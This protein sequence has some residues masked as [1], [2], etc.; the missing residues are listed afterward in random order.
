[1]S[2]LINTSAY[3]PRVRL[4]GILLILMTISLTLACGKRGA[5]IPPNERVRQRV[6]LSAFQRGPEV[7]LSWKMP[8]R[9]AGRS[10]VQNIGRVDV[11]RLADPVNA[12][13]QITEADFSNRSTIVGSVE[14]TNADFANQ[15]LTYRDRLQFSTQPAR[16]RYAVR[17]VN[18]SG[19]RAAFSNLVTVQPGGRVSI[20]PSDLRAVVSQDAI[21]LNWARPSANLD[22]ST[23]ANLIG[24]NIYRSLSDKEPARLLTT[25]P[26]E[27]E[28]FA[29][30]FFEFEK[31]Y[32]YFVRAVSLGI[33]GEPIESGETNIVEVKPIDTFPPTPPEALT[34][35]AVPGTISIFFALNPEKDIK[36]YL[37]FRSEDPSRPVSEWERLTPEPIV[38]NSYQDRNVRSGIAYSYYVVAVDTKG[39]ASDASQIVSE[40]AP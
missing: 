7:L 12:P 28:A 10:S 6:D 32:F 9:N 14:V 3:R 34:I 22:G 8:A 19:Q 23:P 21:Q 18:A 1:M 39:N 33:E 11:Y 25:K 38:A 27:S 29:D 26:V 4:A 20:A 16:L 24:Y 40:I 31:T 37:I 17:L 5:P 35:A 2:Q 36:G 15:T 30:E 13:D